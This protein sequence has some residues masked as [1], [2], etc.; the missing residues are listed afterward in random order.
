MQADY[1]KIRKK[2]N[3]AMGQLSGVSKMVEEDKYCIDISVQILAVISALKG[4]NNDILEAHFK[5]CVVSAVESNDS[6]LINEKIDE[7][8]KIITK[9]S[10]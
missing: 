6:E 1:K 5:S 4:I 7:V 9:L 3:I 10:R 2:L 8:M